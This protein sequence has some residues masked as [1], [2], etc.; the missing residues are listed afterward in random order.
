MSYLTKWFRDKILGELQAQA[1]K[2]RTMPSYFTDEFREKVNTE[3]QA[4]MDRQFEGAELVIEIPRADAMYAAV[5]VSVRSKDGQPLMEM[6]EREVP[7][8]GGDLRITGL[9]I[10]MDNTVRMDN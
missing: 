8:A 3:L 7:V 10:G 5:K 4:W 9:K 1:D 6:P 2:G